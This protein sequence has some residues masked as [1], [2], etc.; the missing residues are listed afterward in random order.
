MIHCGR[1]INHR[2]RMNSYA[3]TTNGIRESGFNAPAIVDI[4]VYCIDFDVSR[5]GYDSG[6]IKLRIDLEFWL[7]RPVAILRL[8]GACREARSEKARCRNA[9]QIPGKLPFVG[10]T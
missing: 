1:N 3:Y 4:T 5:P 2:I 9:D 10:R 8:I 7:K 6:Q